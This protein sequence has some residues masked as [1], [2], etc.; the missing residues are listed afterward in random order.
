MQVQVASGGNALRNQETS[1]SLVSTPSQPISRRAPRPWMAWREHRRIRRGRKGCGGPA[2]RPEHSGTK[3]DGPRDGTMTET[4]DTRHS[5]AGRGGR[6]PGDTGNAPGSTSR[7]T[8]SAVARKRPHVI[9]RFFQRGGERPIPTGA[10]PVGAPR[11]EGP[12][13]TPRDSTR[14]WARCCPRVEPGPESHAGPTRRQAA[15]A[16]SGCSGGRDGTRLRFRKDCR[17]RLGARQCGQ[18]RG[19]PEGN[20][21]QSV[22]LVAPTRAARLGRTL[23]IGLE[24]RRRQA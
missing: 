2:G 22:D 8:H 4:H 3:P 21:A 10:L 9:S 20:G 19:A 13:T 18:P 7:R 6:R 5:P 24:G 1:R 11:R 23:L 17:I 14:G 15:R 16:A 12:M